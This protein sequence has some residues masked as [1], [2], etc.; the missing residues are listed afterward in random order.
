MI[1]DSAADCPRSLV[2]D[3]LCDYLQIEY[4]VK[5]PDE[6]ATKAYDKAAVKCYRLTVPQQVNGDDC[7]LYVLKFAEFF[8]EVSV[9]NFKRR[10]L[11]ILTFFLQD[12]SSVYRFPTKSFK[13]WFTAKSA[14]RK[15]E[16]IQQLLL[17]M[18]HELQP[19]KA[20]SVSRC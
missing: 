5:R 6:A 1:F 15:R 7:G 18:M 11:S 3:T 17:D 2:A 14:A 8:I 10:I 16:E 4:G 20:K 12:P 13:D 19:E 9:D